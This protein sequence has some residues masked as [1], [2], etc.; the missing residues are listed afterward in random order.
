MRPLEYHQS[1]GLELPHPQRKHSKNKL[2]FSKNSISFNSETST[3]LILLS[4]LPSI[5]LWL[6]PC[7]RPNLPSFLPLVLAGPFLPV[8]GLLPPGWPAPQ[9]GLPWPPQSTVRPPGHSIMSLLFFSQ[10]L[11]LSK[12]SCFFL[13]LCPLEI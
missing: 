7:H 2:S 3:S 8:W 6:P 4:H 10:D 9:G 11:L 1:T 12:V 5:S 13:Y